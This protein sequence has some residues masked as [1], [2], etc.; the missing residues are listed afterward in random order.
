MER[1]MMDEPCG[2]IEIDQERCNLCSRC[3]VICD[4]KVLV[5]RDEGI[6]IEHP[7]VCD[8]CGTC[9]EVCPEDAIDCAFE[10]VWDKDIEQ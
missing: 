9:Q 1:W 5:L 10:I 3:V 6:V 7:Q 4:R 2:P 8:G